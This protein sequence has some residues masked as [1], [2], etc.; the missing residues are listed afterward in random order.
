MKRLMVTI[1]VAAFTATPVAAQWAGMP[2]WNSPKGGTGLTISGDYASNNDEASGGSAFGARASLGLANLTITAGMATWDSDLSSDKITSVGG[3]A[4]FR[5]IGGSLLPV[6]VNFLFG[7]ARRNEVSPFPAFTTLVVGG[8][9]SASL[10]VPG[11]GLEPYLSVAN[12]WHVGSGLLDTESNFG[13]T[14]GANA[15]FGV[16]G[17]HV[18][19]DSEA[20]EGGGTAGVIG[21]GAHIQLR[22]PIGL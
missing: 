7:A 3:T 18:A 17:V 9:A 13:W 22:A 12:R 15:S 8:G 2:V 4:A 11:V 16:L 6:A 21:L 1:A 14:I 5:I 20:L 10:P 19:Y